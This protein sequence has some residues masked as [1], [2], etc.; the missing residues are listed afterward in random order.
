MRSMRFER[1]SQFADRIAQAALGGFH[2][3]SGDLTD[4]LET[5][6]AFFIKQKHVPLFRRQLGQCS[7]ERSSYLHLRSLHVRLFGQRAREMI[8]E[9]SNFLHTPFMLA[10][11]APKVID[12]RVVSDAI[13]KCI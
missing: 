11:R 2:S 9:L 1:R 10:T 4:L 3:D 5:E 13:Q 8:F 6:P 12:G 7:S